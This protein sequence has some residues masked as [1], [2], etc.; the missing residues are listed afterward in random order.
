[1]EGICHV[2]NTEKDLWMKLSLAYRPPVDKPK[3]AG[4]ALV[5]GAGVS[6]ASNLPNWKNLLLQVAQKCFRFSSLQQSEEWL[7]Q[8]K[9]E[10]FTLPAIATLLEERSRKSS[11]AECSEVDLKFAFLV[12]QALYQNFV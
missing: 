1:M 9:D 11:L 2:I 7:Q 6:L 10:G 3:S 5:L 12:R 4:I 8:M